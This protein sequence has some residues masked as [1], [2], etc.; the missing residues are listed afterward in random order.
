MIGRAVIKEETE[1]PVE[2]DE[3]PAEED[4]KEPDE[5]DA[6]DDGEAEAAIDAPTEQVSCGENTYLVSLISLGG[7]GG[8]CKRGA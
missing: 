4:T 8:K 3:A 6:A 1:A 7:R 2:D 5:E